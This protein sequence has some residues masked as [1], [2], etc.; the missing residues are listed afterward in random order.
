[1]PENI[2]EKTGL[3]REDASGHI[4]L[5]K[6]IVGDRL[7][8]MVGI[9]LVSHRKSTERGR[10]RGSL[11]LGECGLSSK[12]VEAQETSKSRGEKG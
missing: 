7:T 9:G 12:I 6:G 1:M 10:C 11:P 2:V 8:V 5:N 3:E 4:S